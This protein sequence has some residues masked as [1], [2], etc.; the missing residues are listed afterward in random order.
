MTGHSAQAAGGALHPR[1]RIDRVLVVAFL[2]SALTPDAVTVADLEMRARATRLLGEHQRI[3]DAKLFKAAKKKLG[4]TSRRDGFGRGGEW[5]WTLPTVPKTNVVETAL[6]IVQNT[7]APVVY[8][9]HHSR[10]ER[11]DVL[12]DLGPG[13]DDGLGG[14]PAEWVIGVKLLHLARGPRDVPTHRWQQ[15][16]NDCQHF[17]FSVEQWAARA[18]EIGW[19]TE[20]LFGCYWSRPLDHLGSAG[21]LWHLVGGRLVRLHRDWAVIA[22]ANGTERVFHRRPAA[23]QCTLPWRLLCPMD[24]ER[25]DLSTSGRD[26]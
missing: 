14:I 7:P 9:E 11:G 10:P 26:Q 17:V 8:A 22:G 16:V 12:L 23:M 25:P 3:T 2:Q 20:S 24:L 19:T 4:I 6:D 1:S 13:P 5:L 18:A 15:L 21:L